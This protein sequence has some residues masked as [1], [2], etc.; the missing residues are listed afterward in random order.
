MLAI[1]PRELR[2]AFDY[3]EMD[4]AESFVNANRKGLLIAKKN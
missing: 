1:L 2:T 3:G 4:G